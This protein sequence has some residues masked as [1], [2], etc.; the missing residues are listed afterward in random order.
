MWNYFEPEERTWY[1]WSLDGAHLW[2]RKNGEEWRFKL[3]SIPFKRIINDAHGPDNADPPGPDSVSIAV[4]AG[5][6]VGLCPHPS[7]IPYIVSARN[8]VSILPGAEAWFTI[9]LPPV[10]R[11]QLE[12]GTILFEASPFV[13]PT[14]WFGDKISGSLCLSLPIELE[15]ETSETKLD[16][17]KSDS[18]LPK[19]QP[20][21]ALYLSCHSLI[22]CRIVVRNKSK[23]ALDVKRLAIFTNLMNIYKVDETL[24]SD[25]VVITAGTD[26]SL[27]TNMNN[28]GYENLEKIHVAS[29]SAI[30]EVLIM[31]G[32]SFLR[33]IA[34][35]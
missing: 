4:A 15:P 26:G 30:N 19:S 23:E 10:L 7:S 34:G 16:I 21:S 2:M 29:K 20:R 3:E 11:F 27:K 1:S 8:D 35:I 32:V 28:A 24:I 13:T 18:S 14:T 5:K 33:N 31:R 9:A 12:S 6:K 25:T 22:Q 17:A